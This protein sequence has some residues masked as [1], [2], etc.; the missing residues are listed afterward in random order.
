MLPLTELTTTSG[1][2]TY[3]TGGYIPYI[4]IS[5]STPGTLHVT[6][7][8]SEEKMKEY[9]EKVDRHV[10]Q[11]EEDIDYFNKELEQQQEQIVSLEE[12]DTTNLNINMEQNRKIK[13]LEDEVEFLKNYSS[14]LEGRIMALEGKIK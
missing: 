12:K 2:A 5:A 7:D 3:N 4:P 9:T 10:D 1:T 13:T 14:Y 8:T 6:Y 11:L